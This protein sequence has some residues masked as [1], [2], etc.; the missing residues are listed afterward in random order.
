M[1]TTFAGENS[2]SGASDT[3]Q[4]HEKP[5]SVEADMTKWPKRVKHRKKVL[6]KIYRPCAGRG[7]YR[8]ARSV[9]GKR[10]MK[11]FPT[12]S[13]KGEALEYAEELVKDLA[14]GSQVTALTPGQARDALAALSN[15]CKP[16][17]LPPDA[18]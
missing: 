1:R 5:E 8:V 6:A 13:G 7:S 10:M 3:V 15:G 11:S 12:Y 18:A 2:N 4:T 14:E 9:A 17:T 16:S